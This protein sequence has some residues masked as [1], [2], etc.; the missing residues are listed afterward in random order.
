M[1]HGDDDYTNI[2][3]RVTRVEESSKSA[4]K[5]IDSIDEIYKEIRDLA[6]SVNKLAGSVQRLCDDMTDVRGR[7]SCI[8]GK[9]GKRWDIIVTAVL[10]IALGAIMGY[11][12]S[13]MLI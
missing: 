5:R 11:I 6:I 2:S 3:E 8:E 12:I 4:H 9:P 10:N 13:H 7:V 1:A